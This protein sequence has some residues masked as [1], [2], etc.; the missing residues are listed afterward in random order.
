MLNALLKI[1]GA[2]LTISGERTLRSAIY[3]L[4]KRLQR[5]DVVARYQNRLQVLQD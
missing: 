5:E 3:S 4:A 1:D 2:G